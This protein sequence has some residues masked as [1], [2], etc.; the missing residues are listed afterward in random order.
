MRS[1]APYMVHAQYIKYLAILSINSEGKKWW[2][3]VELRKCL[4]L[5][6]FSWVS[7]VMYMR[8]KSETRDNE[9]N[10]LHHYVNDS[11]YIRELLAINWNL[12]TMLQS[13]TSCCQLCLR[14]TSFRVATSGNSFRTLICRDTNPCC[15][16]PP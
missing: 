4:L 15:H 3:H 2:K 16:F 8:S 7:S 5:S 12:C 13:E 14:C 6:C 10:E 1:G 11:L 9:I